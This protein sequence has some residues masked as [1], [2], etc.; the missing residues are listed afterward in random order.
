[1]SNAGPFSPLTHARPASYYL[2][3][4]HE[5]T[6]TAANFQK[7]VLES[8][9]PV[10]LDFWAE[11]CVPCKMIAPAMEQLAEAYAGKAKVGKVNVDLEAALADRFSIISI[12][13]LVVMK[14]GLEVSRNAGAIPKPEIEKLIKGNL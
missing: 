9:I 13:C 8:A 4:S 6:V 3:M 14:G 2:A 11:W 10:L 5:I 12:P 7:E 1:M